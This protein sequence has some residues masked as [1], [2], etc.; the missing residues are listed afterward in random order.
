MT[1]LV[2]MCGLPRSGSTLLVNLIN[3]HPDVYGSPDSLLSVMMKG[4]QSSL[5]DHVHTSQYDS[6]ISYN[7]FYNFCREGSTSWMNTL[8]DKKI[9]LDKSRMWNE[10]IDITRNTFPETKF[11]ICI[12]DLRGIYKSILKIEDKTPMSYKDQYLFGDQDY[13]YRETDIEEVKIDSVFSEPMIRKNL[14]IIKE[15][16]D[17]NKLDEKFLFVKYEDL[18]INPENELSNIYN[19]IGIPSFKNDLDNIQQIPFHDTVFLPYGKHKI[20]SKLKSSNPWE[21]DLISKSEDKILAENYWYY[22]EF[23]PEIVSSQ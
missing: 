6:D 9:F 2:P 23:Y 13:D 14:I 11:I 22:E 16:L 7:L 19:F 20:K 21:F 15:L 4:M 8:T 1:I 5:D 12:R 18:I 17:C 3:Q 10:I